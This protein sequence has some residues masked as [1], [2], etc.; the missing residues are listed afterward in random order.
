[1]GCTKLAASL[2]PLIVLFLTVDSHLQLVFAALL[3]ADH[4]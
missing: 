1:M 2:F 4:P 3:Q